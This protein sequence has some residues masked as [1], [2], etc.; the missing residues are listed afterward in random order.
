[1]PPP[2]D[3]TRTPGVRFTAD[4]GRSDA[5]DD[6]DV[7]PLPLET[8]P[9]ER[10]ESP[11]RG[12]PTTVDPRPDL[13]N[14]PVSPADRAT[15]PALRAGKPSR[16][17]PPPPRSG[18]PARRTSDSAVAALHDDQNTAVARDPLAPLQSPLIGGKYRLVKRIGE[19]GMG[20]VFKVTHAQLGK[21]FAL[22]IIHSS[23]Q[24]DPKA[25]ESFFREAR[26]ASSLAHP[27]IASVVDFGEDDAYGAYMV[28]E[29]LDGE[30]LS[31][32]LHR[33]KQ[34]SLRAA[35]DILLQCAEALQYIHGHRIIHCDIK[36][37]NIMLCDDPTTQRSKKIVKLLDFGL[38]RSANAARHTGSLSGTP[39]YVAPERIR[40]EP[41]T[42]QSDIYGLGI[43]FYELLTGSVPWDGNVAQIL[44]GHLEKQPPSPSARL[45]KPVDP[46]VEQLIFKALKKDPAERHKDMS[47]FIYELR[48]V[49]DMLGF[50]RRAR[51]GGAKKIV[52]ER[53][54]NERDELARALFDHN[55]LPLAMFSDTGT[56]SVAN[57]AF[58]KFLMGVAVAVEGL[59]VQA[60]PLAAAWQTFEQD[61]ARACAG[62][63]IRR[64]IEF[65]LE[66]GSVR[67]L[68]MWL[69]PAPID[70]HAAF[71]L[72]PLDV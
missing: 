32:V 19:G 69:E 56:I 31:Q 48:T 71:G 26:L 11:V 43:L 55:R 15:R 7:P 2:E 53:T 3:E 6:S 1:M 18:A 25:R 49:M 40:G 36:T 60:T 37:E 51:R 35:C 64:M 50:G 16:P 22:K 42:P 21:T 66:D 17:P 61:L 28:M 47:A 8:E 54:P 24:Q 39:H 27:N 29:Y 46:A 34:L 23:T 30:M 4:L 62:E 10:M 33:E 59:Q 68:L 45:G 12:E 67:R 20:K 44:C 65:D 72:H 52:V 14:L 5:F 57:A 13:V 58:A 70:G 9:F 38:A 63:S 41:P